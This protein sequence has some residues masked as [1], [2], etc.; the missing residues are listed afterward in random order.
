MT[1][2]LPCPTRLSPTLLRRPYGVDFISRQGAR[3]RRNLAGRNPR[4][5]DRE[6][7]VCPYD[8]NSQF[9][10]ELGGA[11]LETALATVAAAEPRVGREAGLPAAV[12][13]A[14]GPLCRHAR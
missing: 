10:R 4:D 14:P 3:K 13:T 12:S 7:L 2:R 6:E 9:W 11:Q 1:C 8:A 5:H